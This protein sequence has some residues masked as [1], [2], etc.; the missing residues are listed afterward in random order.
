MDKETAISVWV[1]IERKTF[2]QTF[3]LEEGEVPVH[4]IDP[5][6]PTELPVFA[7]RLDGAIDR[8]LYERT[9]RLFVQVTSAISK[10]DVGERVIGLLELAREAGVEVAFENGGISLT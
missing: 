9:F 3:G 1:A 4:G 5:R 6:P 7:V 2:V 8:A 10:E